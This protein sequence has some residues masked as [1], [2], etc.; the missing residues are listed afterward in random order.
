[1]IAG[2]HITVETVLRDSPHQKQWTRFLRP[3]PNLTATQYK[4]R[5]STP[6]SNCLS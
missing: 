3:I 1:M 5:W 2:T 6:Q 4:P